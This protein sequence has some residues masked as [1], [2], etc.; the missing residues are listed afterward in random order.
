MIFLNIYGVTLQIFYVF[1]IQNLSLNIK[2]WALILKKT[3]QY[4]VLCFSVSIR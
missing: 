1:K 4:W 2:I 3:L